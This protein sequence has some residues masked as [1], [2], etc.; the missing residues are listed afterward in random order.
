MNH[1]GPL[2]WILRR[3]YGVRLETLSASRKTRSVARRQHAL[4]GQRETGSAG[5]PTLGGLP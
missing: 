4:P 3:N 2:M 1:L 5:P